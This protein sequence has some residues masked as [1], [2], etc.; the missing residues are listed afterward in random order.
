MTKNTII[1]FITRKGEVV[2]TGHYSDLPKML[3]KVREEAKLTQTQVAEKMKIS[4]QYIS[5]AEGAFKNTKYNVTIHPLW[6]RRFLMACGKN[7]K[8]EIK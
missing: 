4:N 8:I 1:S 3:T 6:I 7:Y 5:Q 2:L